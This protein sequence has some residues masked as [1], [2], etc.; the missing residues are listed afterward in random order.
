MQNRKLI[1]VLGTVQ[2]YLGFWGE[3]LNFSITVAEIQPKV[4]ER[5]RKRWREKMLNFGNG[6][7]EFSLSNSAARAWSAWSEKEKKKKKLTN[8]LWQCHCRNR[9]INFFFSY[10]G[11]GIIENWGKKKLRNL[12]KSKKKKLSC[13]Q[14]FYKIFT[15]NH[16]WLVIISSK[17]FVTN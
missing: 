2:S 6:D 16:T 13:P 11:N 14:Y 10:C 8:E 1:C 4:W 12:W 9:G 15:I 5:R 3:R 17:K 7:T